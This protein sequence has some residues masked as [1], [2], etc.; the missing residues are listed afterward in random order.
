[1]IR[2]RTVG[3]LLVAP[4]L[5]AQQVPDSAFTPPISS[6]TFA[7]GAGP[8]VVIDA[9]HHNLHTADRGFLP[10]AEMLRRD[11][12][13]VGGNTQS[14]SAAGLDSVDLLVIANA[15]HRRNL[16]GNWVLPTPSAF[17]AA[18]ISAVRHW[19]DQGGALLLIADHMPFPGAAADLAA[20][21]GVEM[22]NGF[23][24]D[25]ADATNG[26]FTFRR[27]D[28]TLADH[29]VT[30]G[31]VAAERIDS[32][33]GFT[34]NAF[35]WPGAVPLLVLAPGTAVFLPDTAWR[36]GPA[37]PRVTGAGMLQGAV[38]RVGRGRVAVFGEAA[39]F[40][41]Q[42]AGPNRVPVGMNAARASQNPA[43]VRNLVR[44]LAGGG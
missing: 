2:L 26:I 42:L 16:G 30:R 21:F 18:E 12:Y 15:L 25:S 33:I 32:I 39:M 11:G 5:T 31:R 13:R 38:S 40:T 6:P 22:P 17:S 7:P 19:V 37:T 28:G 43:F 9:A 10:F 41:A 35:R 1:M 8:V 4:A 14:F 24:M 20:A 34:G 3:L 29:P 27:A 44:W 36:F 23:A